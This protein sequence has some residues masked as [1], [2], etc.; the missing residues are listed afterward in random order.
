MIPAKE[1]GSRAQ[2]I[3]G[4]DGQALV[5]VADLGGYGLQIPV[6]VSIFQLVLQAIETVVPLIVSGCQM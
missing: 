6:E 4:T 5:E 1:R 3:T 2:S